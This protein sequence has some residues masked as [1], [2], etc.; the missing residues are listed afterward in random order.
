MR[1]LFIALLIALPA[2][3]LAQSNYHEGYVLKNNGDTLKGY[4][5][6]REWAYSP[7]SVEFKPNKNS[8][9][10]LQFN[11]QTIKGFQ[12]TGFETYISYI[13]LISTNRNI[14]PDIPS[15]LDTIRVQRAI[16]LKQLVT[17]NHI[18]LYLN[19]EVH[20]NRFFIAETNEIPVELK[21]YEYYVSSKSDEV[22]DNIFRGQLI[23]LADKFKNGNQK[24]L[25]A[26]AE[27]RYNEPDIEQITTRLN[28]ENVN[29]SPTGKN[30]NKRAQLVRFFAGLGVNDITTTYTY[31]QSITGTTNSNGTTFI[32]NYASYHSTTISPKINLGLDIFINP[33]VQQFIFRSELS[34]SYFNGLFNRTV[35]TITGDYVTYNYKFTQYTT[36]LTPQLLFNI[37]NTDKLK[38][39]IDAGVA[40]N[41]SSY[42]YNNAAE[43][44][45]NSL[46]LNSFWAYFPFQAGVVFN[47]KTELYFTYTNG[48]SF[49][50]FTDFSVSNQYMCL[51]IKY[52]F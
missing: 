19:N 4:I 23:L 50:N 33:N 8:D 16:F 38:F 39:Y 7:L 40:L 30:T 9:E 43:V 27:A 3:V 45:Q 22:F 41:L 10:V 52:L 2:I 29:S 12:V 17:G 11:P 24:L 14:F 51:G 48:S 32:Y 28:D 35:E 42:G 34:F 6:Y 49:S 44:D 47:K 26:I 20:E 1:S 5:N 46:Q 31:S 21:Y 37:Y 36:S 18:T 15:N 13:G 25:N